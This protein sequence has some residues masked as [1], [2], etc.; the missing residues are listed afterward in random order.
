MSNVTK[1]DGDKPYPNYIRHYIKQQGYTIQE[2][3]NKVGIPRRTLTDYICGIRPV[4]R[5]N[6]KKL[7]RMLAC[8]I[9]DLIAE[10]VQSYTSSLV[11]KPGSKAEIF[12]STVKQNTHSLLEPRIQEM[13]RSRRQT[14]QQL[15]SVTGAAI[16]APQEL[17]TAEPWERL[18]RAL[19]KP[20][21]VDEIVLNHL[22]LIT[23]SYWQLFYIVA[24][25]DLISGVVGHL[26]TTTSLLQHSQPVSVYKRLCSIASKTA[27]LI[28][29]ISFD[30][31]NHVAANNY[32]KVSF[33]VAL[34]TGN[35]A[36][37]AVVLG[38]MAT[39]PTNNGQSQIALPLLQEARRLSAQ[40]ATLTTRAW[41]AAKE[42]EMW[43]NVQE[44][45]ACLKALEE[46][47]LINNQLTPEEDPYWTNFDRPLMLGFKGVCCL[48]VHKLEVAQRALHEALATI[49][50]S[51]ARQKSIFLTDLAATF[52]QQGEPQEASKYLDQALAITAQT[53]SINS[54]QRIHQ[55]RLE[56]EPWKMMSCIKQLDEQIASILS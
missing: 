6:L 35:D 14:L 17:L 23:E 32:N 56:L 37:R 5:D 3:A 38:R 36:L 41:L 26:Q 1:N 48:H 52:V 12:S 29:R 20:C 15:F 46:A 39:I 10:P 44:E 4:P 11:E 53:K 40:S 7:A 2:V 30:Q 9:K 16:T 49:A 28:G 34:E 54:I 33:E 55:V 8:S 21:P 31:S 22:E 47:E 51:F 19:A 42:A 25:H 27:L 43:A 24:S 18:S 45:V 13:N 50:P